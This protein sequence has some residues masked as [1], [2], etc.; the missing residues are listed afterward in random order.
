MAATGEAASAA[1]GLAIVGMDCAF[2]GAAGLE[3]YWELLLRGG[4]VVGEV[5]AQRWDT[6]AVPGAPAL[7]GFLADADVFDHEFFTVT[8]REAAV[9]DPHHRL[10]LQCA[11]RALEDSGRPPGRRG[12]AD[13]TEVGVYVGVMGG[14]WGRLTL[15]DPA[16]VTPQLGAGTSAGMTANRLSYHLNLTG[17]SIAVDTACSSALVAVHLAANA[18]LA[19]ECDTA[20]AAGVNLQ[21]TPT[22]NQVYAR[23]GLAA[24]DGL[25]KPFG[26]GAD[27]IG[28]SDGLGVVVLRR[29][30]DALA[31]GQRVYAVLR[32]TAVNQDGRSN[33]VTAPNRWAQQR[34]LEAA[35]RRAGVRPSEIT[36]VEAHGTGTALGDAIECAALGAVHGVERPRPVA[37]G[38]V[39]GNLGHTEGA[40]GIAGLIKTALAL[41]HRI[42]PASKGADQVNGRLRLA[43]RGLSL[44]RAP[45]RL[46]AGEQLAGVS[47]FGMGGTNAHAVLASAP[48]PARPAAARRGAAAPGVF[49]LT[50]DSPEGLRRNLA[51]QAEAIGRRPK[52]GAAALCWSSNRARTTLPYRYATVAR[53]SA[54]LAAELRRAAEG[55]AEALPRPWDQPVVA[56]VF[57]GQG[58]QYP[59][60]TAGLHRESPS[61][62]HHLG[63]ASRALATRLGF[64]VEELIT[65]GAE[66]IHDPLTSQPALFAVGY[67]LAHTL[68]DL[69]LRPAAVTGHS[70]G[71]IA[72]A[73]VAGALQLE[74]AAELVVERAIA[75]DATPAGGMLAV[76]ASLTQ[77]VELLAGEPE[78][79]IS[80]LAELA[81][82]ATGG[83]SPGSRAATAGVAPRAPLGAASATTRTL[84]ASVGAQPELAV[85]AVNG[86]QDV[87]L[88]GSC[89]ALARVEALLTA[90]GVRSRPLRVSRGFH[91]PLIA[92]AAD[93]LRALEL[94]PAAP[95]VPLYSTWRGRLLGAEPMDGAYW[96]GHAAEPVR[97]ADALGALA[98][99]AR[100]THLVEIGP[101]R[102]LLPLVRRGGLAP[103]AELLHPA[104]GAE[105]TGR[106]LAETA[107]ALFRSGLDPEWDALYEAADR[108]TERLRPYVFATEH[109]FRWSG[110]CGAAAPAAV[111]PLASVGRPLG[112]ATRA[113]EP[114][115][116][117]PLPPLLAA[118]I[119]AVTELGGYPQGHVVGTARFYEDLAFDSVMT[120][121]LKDRLESR[122]PQLG[123][124]PMR[125]LLP[126]LRTVESLTEYLAGLLTEQ[127]A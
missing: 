22:L 81:G 117:R 125:E 101:K 15:G 87:V 68:I 14:E 41:H 75:M 54:E 111:R 37:I 17:P 67:A 90:R 126:A 79:A 45:L 112:S 102:L 21:L 57:T 127:V 83:S 50:A 3:A 115:A 76:R 1:R 123:T 11:W 92:P 108:R 4:R 26:A 25:C 31:A 72:A 88:S 30:A 118:V 36:F 74:E 100:P 33:G 114:A 56:F 119:E 6:A 98:A 73:T 52:S 51:A 124:V 9:M 66:A 65:S 20:L 82:A 104:P 107:A 95:T 84:A 24:P 69:G 53:D 12:P 38:S 62:R 80:G 85:A 63:A 99:Q 106:E 28:R 32:G 27:G 103:G 86:P 78:L 7:G 77:L 43:E 5:P 105:A 19:G 93:R 40:A 29:L 61:Y 42:V 59:G 2:P 113:A 94:C 109:R 35:Y 13:D 55:G 110:A 116:G 8:P 89:A 39:K 97:F 60:M 23:L 58:C 120:V 121:Q 91:S 46:P 10:L 34:V 71:E 70:L 18:L 64:S 122:L 44:L 49:T 96:A 48:A 47:S 16:A